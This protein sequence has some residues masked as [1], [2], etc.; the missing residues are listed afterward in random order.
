MCYTTG[1]FVCM[2]VISRK[3][4]VDYQLHFSK[5]FSYTCSVATLCCETVLIHCLCSVQS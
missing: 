4:G 3:D 5:G 2:Y 1:I